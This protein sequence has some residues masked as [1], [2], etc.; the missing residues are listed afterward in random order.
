MHCNDAIVDIT[1]LYDVLKAQAYI[2]VYTRDNGSQH[3]EVA[4]TS[5][6]NS[7]APLTNMD[8]DDAKS[9]H[10]DDPTTNADVKISLGK[11]VTSVTADCTDDL[12][13]DAESL[14]GDRAE[15]VT[16]VATTTKGNTR[17]VGRPR[18]A[19]SKPRTGTKRVNSEEVDSSGRQKLPGRKRKRTSQ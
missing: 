12:A 11:R 10:C 15:S 3:R 19:L 7:H 1:T 9:V 4:S 14:A 6:V 17:G 8:N 18:K 5:G 2:L 13:T 16:E